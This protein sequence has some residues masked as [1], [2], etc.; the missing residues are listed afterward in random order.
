MANNGLTEKEV[1][2]AILDLTSEKQTPTIQNIRDRL[3]S[4]SF[5]TISKHLKAW[6]SKNN[7]DRLPA[8]PEPML[9]VAEYYWGHAYKAAEATL[10]SD[11]AKLDQERIE[12][13]KEN[14]LISIANE[15]LEIKIHL[16]EKRLK[17]VET[18]L[19]R[20]RNLA[21]EKNKSSTKL[22]EQFTQVKTKLESMTERYND[23]KS[24]VARLEKDLSDFLKKI[25][26]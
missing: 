3:G 21:N 5:A 22:S 2:A 8:V 23:E 15:K 1:F 11:R 13:E 17:E 19:E 18:I 10:A 7:N 9:K 12:M 24:R 6:I 16:L 26:K 4:G 25:K 20:E 14:Q